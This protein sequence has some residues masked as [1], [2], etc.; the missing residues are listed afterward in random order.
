MQVIRA[1][2]LG[3]CFGVRDALT[4]L[5]QVAEPSRVTVH[6]ELV[7]NEV[8]QERIRSRGF[9]TVEE[10]QRGGVPATPEVLITAHGISDTE[11]ARLEASGKI[12]R[13]TT[14]PLV[15]RAHRAAL[16][17]QRQGYFVVVI[18]RRGHVEVRGIV[19]DLESYVVVQSPEE[20]V[21]Y[22]HDRL[23]VICQTTATERNVRTVREALAARNP[24]AQEI[25][26]VDTVCRP[27]KL[28]QR[29]LERLLDQVDAMVVVG[30]Q[31]SNNTR[32]LATRC[33]E[34]GIPAYHVQGPDDLDP[35]WFDGCDILGLSAGTS[36][37]DETID[38]VHQAL[39]RIRPRKRCREPIHN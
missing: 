12:L 21:A 17:L 33:R 7:H 19:E 29:A 22:P 24:Q 23:G 2:A 25:R 11:R 8:V 27:T 36:T 10:D 26:F 5:D 6:G 38:A 18:G 1:E 20:V 34:R 28:R 16:A 39:V 35:S 14:C 32:E 4:V 3:M 37:L 30:G 9:A 13:D 15:Q 31:N